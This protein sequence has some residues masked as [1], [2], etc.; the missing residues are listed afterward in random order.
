LADPAKRA[1]MQR[2]LAAVVASLGGGGASERAA[3]L[4]RKEIGV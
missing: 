3:T 4:I 2:E 1:A